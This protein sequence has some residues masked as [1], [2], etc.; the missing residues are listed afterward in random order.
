MADSIRVSLP[1]SGDEHELDSMEPPEEA[2]SSMSGPP[3]DGQHR[4]Q[5]RRRIPVACGACRSKKSRVSPFRGSMR[6]TFCPKAEDCLLFGCLGLVQRWRVT[7]GLFFLFSV[8]GTG[9]SVLAVQ[10]KILNASTCRHQSQP[11]LQ[12]QGRKFKASTRSSMI[13][14]DEAKVAN[15]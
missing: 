11:Q 13:T 2:R 9:Q 4:P 6:S 8:M 15:L 12:C 7:D 3:G 14:M 10:L 1:T 5:K